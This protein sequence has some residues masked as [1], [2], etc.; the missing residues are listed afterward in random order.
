MRIAHTVL[1]D[2]LDQREMWLRRAHIPAWR[3][4]RTEAVYAWSRLTVI[5]DR[6]QQATAP[7]VWLD[8]W[9][10]LDSILDAY[11]LDR[12]VVPV[13]GSTD[14]DGLTRLVRP[15]IESSLVRGQLLLAQVRHAAQEA[16]HA[17][18]PPARIDP[19]RRLRDRLDQLTLP[20]NGS[21]ADPVDSDVT[22]RERLGSFAPTVLAELGT[23]GAATVARQLDDEGLRLVEGIAYNAAVNRESARDP[24]IARLLKKLSSGLRGCPDYTGA[25]RHA[26]DAVLG[27]TVAFLATRHDLQRSADV[28]YLKPTTPPPLEVRLQDDFA[29]WLRRGHLAGR[30]DVEVPNVATG[31]VDIKLGFGTTRFFVEVKRVLID[32]SDHRLVRSYLTQAADY[33]GTSATLGILLVLDLTPHPTGVRHLSECAWVARARPAH[34]SVDRYV[35]VAVVVGNRPTPSWYSRAGK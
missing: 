1:S 27:E 8:A 23:A 11:V 19:L 20:A 10:A 5:L 4:P 3:R 24:V 18:E 21:L 25:V 34:S 22:L 30:V 35:V 33:S 31:R 13:P 17:N 14:A 28:D 7:P 29:D 6:A 9:S 2:Q 26:F 12:S 16:E 32:A 15:V